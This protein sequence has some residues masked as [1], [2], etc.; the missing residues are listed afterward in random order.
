MYKA[1]LK[2][3]RFKAALG[4][5]GS[6]QPGNLQELMLHETAVSWIRL[7]LARSVPAKAWEETREAYATRLKRICDEINDTLD[8]EGLCRSF[9]HS[10]AKLIDQEGGR[11]SE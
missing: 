7:R 11:L 1:A 9:L 4:D 8:V 3:H 6:V 2:E 10:V 5:N